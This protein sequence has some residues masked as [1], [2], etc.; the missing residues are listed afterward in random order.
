[1]KPDFLPEQ[2][3]LARARCVDLGLHKPDDKV[4]VATTNRHGVPGIQCVPAW[5]LHMREERRFDGFAW[6]PGWTWGWT[7]TE[8]HLTGEVI[9]IY[10]LG[11]IGITWRIFGRLPTMIEVMGFKRHPATKERAA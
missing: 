10:W 7:G 4:E 1:M 3:R 6:A 5:W 9:E 2:E 11:P 8:D